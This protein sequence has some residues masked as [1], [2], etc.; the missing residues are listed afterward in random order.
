MRLPN[1]FVR[2]IE[3]RPIDGA[4]QLAPTPALGQLD[5]G[6]DPATTPNRPAAG[7]LE[8]GHLDPGR[9]GLGLR[10]DILNALGQVPLSVRG[11][12]LDQPPARRVVASHRQ[13][14]GTAV[15]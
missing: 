12:A 9:V 10:I 13:Q 7:G 4:L 2:E 14:E 15:V 8:L 5:I 11:V 6:G 1:V 3:V